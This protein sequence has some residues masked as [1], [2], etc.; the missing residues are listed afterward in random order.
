[1]KTVLALILL[2]LTALLGFQC[3]PPPSAPDAGGAADAGCDATPLEAQ[4]CPPC[5]CATDAGHD[6]GRDAAPTPV[7]TGDLA[8]QA[9][10]NVAQ[11][12]PEGRAND[13][14]AT[15]RALAASSLTKIDLR[16]CA[17]ARSAADVR[18]CGQFRC[19]Q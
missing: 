10:R 15:L 19:G 13:C 5:P 16:A 1:M 7:P 11:W 9:C 3:V 12:C 8:D 14:A 17:A 4:K 2:S 6:A 18:R